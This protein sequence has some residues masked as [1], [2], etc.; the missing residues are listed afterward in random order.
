[1][2]RNCALDWQQGRCTRDP[3]TPYAGE[4][5]SALPVAILTA[6]V[7]FQPTARM[8][9]QISTNELRIYLRAIQPEDYLMPYQWRNDHKLMKGVTGMPRFIIKET[10][11][12]W[13][14]KA[15]EV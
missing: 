14:P 13:V 12:K 15:I 2:G 7:I 1:M 3:H 6:Y 10:E 11:R 5:R 8:E 4:I 9:Q